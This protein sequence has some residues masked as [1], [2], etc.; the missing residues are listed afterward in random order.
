M[1]VR[2]KQVALKL[3]IKI[4]MIAFVACMG[5][6]VRRVLTLAL[7]II[8]ETASAVY[9]QRLLQAQKRESMQFIDNM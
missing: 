9:A 3:R 4:C 5:S 2:A 6:V 1:I 8:V 7:F